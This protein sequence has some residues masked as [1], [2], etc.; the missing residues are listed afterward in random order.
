MLNENKENGN[1]EIK[2]EEY[3]ECGIIEPRIHKKN[4]IIDSS[5]NISIAK[6]N[7]SFVKK[8]KDSKIDL[9][10][11]NDIQIKTIKSKNASF[12]N[13]KNNKKLFESLFSSNNYNIKNN[14]LKLVLFNKDFLFR[15]EFNDF[16]FNIE[17]SILFKSPNNKKYKKYHL[18]IK[19]QVLLI[20]SYNKERY[21]KLNNSKKIKNQTIINN[22]ESNEH[23]KRIK[24]FTILN[25]LTN[26]S[27]IEKEQTNSKSNIQT[28]NNKILQYNEIY[29]I[30][31]PILILNFNLISVSISTDIDNYELTLNIL[32]LK[33]IS[34]TLK[35][36]SKNK[37]LLQKIYITLQNSIITSFGY[38]INLFG[39]SINKNFFKYYYISYNEFEYKSKT[40]DILLFKGLNYPS[41][42]QRCYTRNEYDHVAILHKK[43]GFLYF[44]DATSKDGCKERN[45]YEF[46]AY[47]WNLLYEKIVYRELIINES[48][49]NLKKNIQKDLDKKIDIFM[50]Q[51]K[52]KKYQMK[53]FPLLC[54]SSKQKYQEE[55]KWNLKEGFICS[56]LIMGAYLQMGICDYLKNINGIFPGDFSQDGFLPMKK[57]FELGP[58]YIIDFSY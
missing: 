53:L 56:S 38:Y 57:P 51:T 52:G 50:T 30:F 3:I 12:S 8:S 5:N 43:N 28:L 6:T 7:D 58:E 23:L 24:T 34:F 41:K 29:D 10:E 54:G 46:L 45:F 2:E 1:L 44:Y 21:L 48:D 55:N 25:K 20:L 15:E 37:Q 36:P 31:H 42:L 33:K 14:D 16:N 26:K 13:N 47:M 27:L 9:M 49:I 18:S 39:V 35:L 40:G 17:T 4:N 22:N 11:S 19:N 32:S